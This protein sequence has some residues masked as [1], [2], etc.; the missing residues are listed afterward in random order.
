[1]NDHGGACDLTDP[2]SPGAALAVL[3]VRDELLEWLV[4][5]DCAVVIEQADGAHRVTI[6]DRVDRLPDAPVVDTEVR[7]YDPDYVA[8]IRNQPGGF[9]VAGAVPAAA[10][11]ALVGHMPYEQARQALMCSDGVTRLVERHGWTWESMFTTANKHSP[12]ALIEAVR[13]ADANDPN[14]RQWRGKLHDDATA[15]LCRFA[16][17]QGD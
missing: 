14:A 5:G 4:L 7:T 11:E 8:T 10:H 16:G 15:A 17:K 2:L 1:M 9:W 12:Q 13:N 6:D 3:R